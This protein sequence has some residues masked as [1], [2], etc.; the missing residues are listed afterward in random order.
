MEFTCSNALSSKFEKGS[1]MLFQTKKRLV[2]KTIPV[3]QILLH[4]TLVLLLH[5]LPSIYRAKPCELETA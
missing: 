2:A 4:V 5:L 1:P 3:N